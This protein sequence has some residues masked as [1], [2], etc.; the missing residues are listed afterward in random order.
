MRFNRPDARNA[1][2][3]A[4]YDAVTGAIT[5]AAERRAHVHVGR[6]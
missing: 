4:L 5:A 6:C 1:F 2:N 3:G